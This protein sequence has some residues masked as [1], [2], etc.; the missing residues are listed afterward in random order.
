MTILSSIAPWVLLISWVGFIGYW[1][2]SS[3]GVKRDR[4]RGVWWRFWWV[5]ITL[6]IVVISFLW[7]TSSLGR[8]V[9][10]SYVLQLLNTRAYGALALLGVV[11]TL[12]GIGFAMWARVH[13][14]RNWSPAPSVKEGHELVTSG[15][16]ALMRHPIYSGIML[17]SLGSALVSPAWIIMLGI[18]TVIF[19]W[20]VHAEEQLMIEQFPELYP[21]YKKR[22]WALIPY[23]W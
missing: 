21:G 2:V 15:P 1:I 22:T 18:V 16:Y 12:C 14:G 23:V 11:C 7:D 4:V 19:V 10:H 5:R 6:V 13:L 3:F 20:R 17:A 9:Q 8:A